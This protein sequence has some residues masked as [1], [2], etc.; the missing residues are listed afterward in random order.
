[1][2]FSGQDSLNRELL[3]GKWNSALRDKKMLL[4]LFA[5]EEIKNRNPGA[6]TNKLIEFTVNSG[7]ERERTIL[8]CLYKGLKDHHP[9]LLEKLPNNLEPKA[10]PPPTS[11]IN[12]LKEY[13]RRSHIEKTFLPIIQTIGEV[14]RD[15]F[16]REPSLKVEKPRLFNYESFDF[17]KALKNILEI[18]DNKSDAELMP[19]V[20]TQYTPEDLKSQAYQGFLQLMQGEKLNPAEMAKDQIIQAITSS[21]LLLDPMVSHLF[22]DRLHLLA[23]LKSDAVIQTKE[24]GI[25][26]RDLMKGIILSFQQEGV[27]EKNAIAAEQFYLRMTFLYEKLL[28][29]DK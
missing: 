4:A 6:E 27:T 17:S 10:L 28:T 12:F 23:A 29:P 8:G 19:L 2:R 9:F 22:Y 25:S 14:Y 7:E 15:L 21:F 3:T 26:M 1:V 16:D 13:V 20:A 11:K 18:I 5:L 24:G